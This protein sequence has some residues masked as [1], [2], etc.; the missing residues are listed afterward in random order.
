M[1]TFGHIQLGFAG[2][3]R[4][5]VLIDPNSY[6]KSLV[7]PMGVKT[8][9]GAGSY[10]AYDGFAYWVQ[11]NWSLGVGMD[12]KEPGGF[13]FGEI[14]SRY[15]ERLF[16][17]PRHWPTNTKA[18]GDAASTWNHPG[19]YEYEFTAGP[20]EEYDAIAIPLGTFSTDIEEVW[21]FQAYD[22]STTTEI[23]LWTG[24]SWPTAQVATTTLSAD[25][26]TMRS[27]YR[28]GAFSPAVTG[29]GVSNYWLV[30]IPSAAASFP[31]TSGSFPASTSIQLRQT[32]AWR[33]VDG[34]SVYRPFFLTDID[35]LPASVTAA[36]TFNGNFYIG[37]SDGKIYK[38]AGSGDDNE[39]YTLVATAAAGILQMIEWW[40]KLVIIE[41][42]SVAEF[43]STGETLSNS[44]F[45]AQIATIH[46]GYF[47]YANGY[48][49][50]YDSTENL[51]TPSSSFDF[52]PGSDDVRGLAGI[53][54]DIL[55]STDTALWKI[56]PGDIIEGVSKWDYPSANHG[57]GMIY[58]EGS[59]FIPYGDALLRY[60]ENVPIQ[61]VWI[62]DAPLPTSRSG[63]FVGLLSTNKELIMLLN[64]TGQST[65]WSWNHQGWHCIA[66][67]PPGFTLTNA[68]Y[69]YSTARIYFLMEEGVT[70]WS[71]AARTDQ[72]ATFQTGTLFEP[73]SW[74]DTG[75]Y[76][77]NLYTVEKD[78][79][80]VQ[81]F[82]NNIDTT[83]PLTIFWKD[84]E[85]TAWERLGTVSEDGQLI[86]WN[87]PDT[88]PA[89]RGIRLGLLLRTSDETISPEVKAII[90]R[91]YPTVID[92]WQYRVP[93]IL[94]PVGAGLGGKVE[95]RTVDA[96]SAHLDS[97][98]GATPPVRFIGFDG[99][100]REVKVPHAVQR[101]NGY[102]VMNDGETVKF[103][104]VYDLTV[105]A[106]LGQDYV[107]PDEVEIPDPTEPALSFATVAEFNTSVDGMY[108]PAF[109]PFV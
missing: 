58:R 36:S 87:D 45:T 23:E 37:L 19:S 28:K 35:K 71:L 38:R 48:Q 9:Q 5:Y 54:D 81:I 68:I 76:Y 83:S 63:D 8:S 55:V 11:E 88:R 13:E 73:D 44:T 77:A 27:G 92:R 82:G 60:S 42:G 22:G 67:F 94:A 72:I 10:D 39:Y 84:D 97:L 90:L 104:I 86:R 32:G 89:T 49:V 56:A 53:N 105:E 4:E 107:V 29:N 14:D 6:S 24:A 65:A 52:F 21:L 41:D 109:V 59:V 69:D 96:M 31:A 3:L 25:S 108:L 103:D 66:I 106:I 93:L 75:N 61:N 57:V 33:D 7:N 46:R 101:P 18:R 34:G 80:S 2:D 98:V 70:F 62:R 51:T 16:L 78:I 1:P 85:S 12:P 95:T 26:T 102:E 47:W 99:L 50:Y 91:H 79:E 43:L 100:E 64:S 15:D 74:I 40:G 30:V 20:D 17:L